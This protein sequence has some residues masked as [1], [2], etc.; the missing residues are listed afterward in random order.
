MR[1]GQ[2]EW[3]AAAKDKAKLCLMFKTERK[4]IK[5]KTQKG[6]GTLHSIIGFE[7]DSK[8]SHST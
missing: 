8:M 3:T 1:A 2:K 4:K 7:E 6:F 5:T